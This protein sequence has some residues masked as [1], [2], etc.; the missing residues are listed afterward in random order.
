MQRAIACK[1]FASDFARFATGDKP[2][3]VAETDPDATVEDAD[4]GEL[5]L[6]S[7]L[8]E[9]M[10]D[11]TLFLGRPDLG[12]NPV[13]TLWA[14]L[15][16]L[17]NMLLQT[18]IA[19]IVVLNMGDPTFAANIIEDLWYASEPRCVPCS[20]GLGLNRGPAHPP[21]AGR[22]ASTWPTTSRT[23]IPTPTCRSQLKCATTSPACSSR[24]KPTPSRTSRNTRPVVPLLSGLC[25]LRSV[26]SCGS[27]RCGRHRAAHSEHS[28]RLPVARACA[29]CPVTFDT[30]AGRPRDRRRSHDDPRRRSAARQDDELRRRRGGVGRHAAPAFLPRD[31]SVPTHRL[32]AALL[33]RRVLHREI[34]RAQRSDPQLH[35]AGGAFELPPC[36]AWLWRV[37][38]PS[39]RRAVVRQVG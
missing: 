2:E 29:L 36:C 15:I 17:L 3:A 24:S 21:C 1:Q 35:R 22:G 25:S 7:D 39:A 20:L 37:C 5:E 14:V 8:D 6:T 4:T 33:R 13:V 27:R 9:S 11:S 18:T 16:L 23:S 28:R 32:I 31:A 30:C 26:L 19:V 10:W 38:T 34:D 12:I